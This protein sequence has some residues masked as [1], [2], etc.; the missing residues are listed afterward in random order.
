VG[1][2]SVAG[3]FHRP[4]EQ[5]ERGVGEDDPALIGDARA[6]LPIDYKDRVRTP[7]DPE[8]DPACPR[9]DPGQSATP[10]LLVDAFARLPSSAFPRPATP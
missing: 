1:E 5:G 3:S 7:A 10:E 2:L 4:A 6:A 8:V 9:N